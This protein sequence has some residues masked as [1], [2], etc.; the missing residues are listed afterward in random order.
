MHMDPLM[1]KLVA[2]ILAILVTGLVL[3]AL[4]QPHVVAYLMTGVFLGPHGVNLV[5]DETT[6]GRLG[7]FGVI[8]LLFFVGMEISP[9]RLMTTWK[10]STLGNLLQILISVGLIWLVGSWLDWPLDRI[11]LIG[12]VISLSSTAVVVKL[13]QD[14]KEIDSKIGQETLGILIVQDLAVIPM[15][16]VLNFLGG[17]PPSY[18]TLGLQV[19]GGLLIF[20][21]LAIILKK[22]TFHLPLAKWVR[23]DH[24]MQVFGALTLAFGLSLLTALLELSAALGAFAA[25][26]IIGASKETQW[27]HH[28]LE[29][30]RVV[31]L[32]L[33][34]VSIG[35]LL[36]LGFLA[37]HGLQILLI[38]AAV[39]LTNTFV[40]A[41]IMKTIGEN[42][43]DSL[44]TGALLAQ[45]G[46]F[47]FIL[48]AV[49]KQSGIIAD[50][51]Y[52]ITIAVIALSL[53]LSPGW[54][55]LIKHLVYDRKN[56]AS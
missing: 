16:L 30:F 12:F 27:V 49:G 24:E 39:F 1:P 36:D 44:Y 9:R 8:L 18:Q 52:Q 48:A 43:Q 15:L 25:G 3:R 51:G 31:F 56:P 10:A 35:M 28:S 21:I 14:R 26:M 40:N 6:L 54:I 47:S 41:V 32:A 53:L 22:E 11:I 13:L 20:S 2:A 42:W 23:D 50:F 37:S 33:F 46:E 19:F 45:I 38:L 55:G 7:A 17:T 34:F 5:G 4:K 29:P